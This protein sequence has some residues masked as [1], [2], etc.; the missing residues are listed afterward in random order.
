MRHITFNASAAPLRLEFPLTWTPPATTEIPTLTV[1]DIGGNTLQAAKAC[2]IYTKTS[3]SVASVEDD[4]TVTLAVG[5]SSLYPGDWIKIRD[6]YGSD[7]NVEVDY[8]ISANKTVNLVKPLRQDHTLGS[9]VYGLFAT[10]T[11]DTTNLTN[12]PKG[13]QVTLVWNFPT[14][15]FSIEETGVISVYSF[16]IQNFEER[17]ANLHPREY[18]A[19][20]GDDRLKPM[21]D[22]A[23]SQFSSELR[24]RNLYL[25]RVVDTDC[26]V[27]CLMA[28]LRWLTLL[29]GDASY[30]TER[31]VARDDYLRQFEMICGAPIWTD[32]NQDLIQSDLEV[33][34]HQVF[35]ERS[36]G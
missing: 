4:T 8:F 21:L 24:L 23:I 30:D 3:L 17:F 36:M 18:A 6:G 34:D 10:V 1:Y 26:V 13:R 19:L 22:E 2:N 5:A 15:G 32:D 16:L 7:E 27:P 14:S 12:Y 11:L 31:S 35:F 33:T 9:E 20:V 25:E 28:K 29:N